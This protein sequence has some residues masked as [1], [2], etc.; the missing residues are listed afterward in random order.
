MNRLLEKI[1]HAKYIQTDPILFEVPNALSPGMRQYHSEPHGQ[2]RDCFYCREAYVGSLEKK[3][4]VDVLYS[5]FF[6]M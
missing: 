1:S 6:E 5:A 3:R 2:V 4:I